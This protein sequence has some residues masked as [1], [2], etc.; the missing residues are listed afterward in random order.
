M[1]LAFCVAQITRQV[2]PPAGC[3]LLATG[4]SW[5]FSKKGTNRIASLSETTALTTKYLEDKSEN[6]FWKSGWQRSQATGLLPKMLSS[7]CFVNL[8][9]ICLF[10]A[11][12]K[13]NLYNRI[14]LGL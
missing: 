9:R 10:G 6:S 7:V 3:E 11:K 13:V 12:K 4:V 2:Q 5:L 1:F 14:V 8:Q